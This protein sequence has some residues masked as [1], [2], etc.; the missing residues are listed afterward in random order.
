[1]ACLISVSSPLFGNTVTV[2]DHDREVVDQYANR[3][4][5]PPSVTKLMVS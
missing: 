5:K 2:F 4:S 1:M 3:Q